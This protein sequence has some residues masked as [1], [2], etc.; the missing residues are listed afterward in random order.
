MSNVVDF[1]V[2]YGEPLVFKGLYGEDYK[3]P[4]DVPTELTLKL[5]HHHNEM[6]KIKDAAKAIEKLH[7]ITLDILKL[8]E[9]KDVRIEDIKKFSHQSLLIVIQ[10]FGNHIRK[11]ESNPNSKSLDS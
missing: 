2:L 11:I 7:A 6:V 1:S 4:Y 8:D 10:E 9:S 5:H 3:I